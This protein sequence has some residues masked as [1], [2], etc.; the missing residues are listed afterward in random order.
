MTWSLEMEHYYHWSQLIE[1]NMTL[2]NHVWVYYKYWHTGLYEYLSGQIRSDETIFTYPPGQNPRDFSNPSHVPPFLD[3]IETTNSTLLELC[4]DN[5]Q[6]L[7][8]VVQTGD[9][10]V[11]RDTLQFEE[12]VT[13]QVIMSGKGKLL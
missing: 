8:D 5:A 9:E 10:N 13:E 12:Q 3:E 7:F 11:G 6:C 1:K 4:G 2:D